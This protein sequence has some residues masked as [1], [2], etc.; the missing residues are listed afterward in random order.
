MRYNI[1]LKFSRIVEESAGVYTPCNSAQAI[2]NYMTGAFDDRPEQEHFYIVMLDRKLRPKGRHLVTIG[3][4]TA[5]LVHPREAFRAAILAGASA[6]ICVH[7]H[8]SG[9]PAPSPA[10]L[11]VTRQLVESG[12][13][14][15]I[16]LIDHV[17][18][19]SDQYD[20]T[21]KGHYSFNEMGAM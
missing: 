9:D 13:I 21:G 7:N 4:Q 14:L 2:V 12:K 1:S 10:D 17:I 5:S 11:Q 16:E 8:P 18:I 19:G 3:T 20:P 15:G 6:I